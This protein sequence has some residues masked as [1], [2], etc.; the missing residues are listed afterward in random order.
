MAAAILRGEHFD[1]KLTATG[2]GGSKQEADADETPPATGLNPR[3][4]LKTRAGEPIRIQFI[5]TNVYAHDGVSDASVRYYVVRQQ[6]AGQKTL[7]S[8]ENAMIEG[9]L[10]FSLKPKAGIVGRNKIVIQQPGIYLLRVETLNTQNE[11]EH[12][13]AIDLQV[14]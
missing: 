12:F 9:S 8:L 11:H 7:P 2:S 4:L 13:A 1:I 10:H 5:M 14:Q 3:P 6:A